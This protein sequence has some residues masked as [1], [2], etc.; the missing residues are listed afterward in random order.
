M[1]VLKLRDWYKTPL[2]HTARRMV[3]AGVNEMWPTLVGQRVLVLGYGLPYISLWPKEADVY[4]AMMGDMGVLPWPENK[5]NRSTFTWDDQLPFMDEFFDAIFVVHGLEFSDNDELM[6][7]ECRRVLK[8]DGRMLIGVPNRA[9]AWSRMDIS[10]FG[11]GQPYSFS[12]IERLCRYSGMCVSASMFS[13]YMPPST[14]K[15]L[16]KHAGLFERFGRYF[17]APLGGVLLAEIKKDM[18]AGT[19]LRVEGKSRLKRFIMRPAMGRV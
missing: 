6:I 10:P 2:G 5:L 18:Y 1:D 11:R 8:N 9:G 19:V 3:Q 16:I 7:D 15:F 17:R 14:H 13:L 12:Q 4:T